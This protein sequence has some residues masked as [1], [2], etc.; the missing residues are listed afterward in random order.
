LGSPDRGHGPISIV[1]DSLVLNAIHRLSR[2]GDDLARCLDRQSFP[3]FVP[4]RALQ[5][6]DDGG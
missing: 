6:I 2:V 3:E 4:A 1:G 5:E